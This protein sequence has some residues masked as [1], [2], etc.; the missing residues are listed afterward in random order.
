MEQL[1]FRVY[2]PSLRVSVLLA[3]RTAIKSAICFLAETASQ[4]QNSKGALSCIISWA[5]VLTLWPLVVLGELL[6]LNLQPGQG[7]RI[8]G[9]AK[10]RL[11][12]AGFI[13]RQLAVCYFRQVIQDDRSQQTSTSSSSPSVSTSPWSINF[14]RSLSYSACSCSASEPAKGS[15]PTASEKKCQSE[16]GD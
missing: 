12:L 5:W 13:Y 16:S 14:S 3:D 6:H 11:L 1:S 4:K 15:M 10:R 2:I 9:H 8:H 7:L